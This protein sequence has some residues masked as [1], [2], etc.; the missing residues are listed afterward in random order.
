MSK[1]YLARGFA[2]HCIIGDQ[3]EDVE[4]QVTDVTII[5]DHYI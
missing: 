4:E 2:V 3:P 1:N 5:F